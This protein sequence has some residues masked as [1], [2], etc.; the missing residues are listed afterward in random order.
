MFYACNI[1]YCLHIVLHVYNY[2]CITGV[3][4]TYVL[5][6]YKSRCNACVADAFVIHLFYTCNN[7]K[8]HTCIIGVAQLTT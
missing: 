8:H 1:A 4:T 3:Y 5:H 2:M 7:I 6:A